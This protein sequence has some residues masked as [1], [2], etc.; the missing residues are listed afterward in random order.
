M[1][2]A[3]LSSPR[4]PA[5]SPSDPS[6]RRN[7][8]Q[9]RTRTSALVAALLALGATVP[10]AASASTAPDPAKA[11]W[12]VSDFPVQYAGLSSIEVEGDATVTVGFAI[13]AGFRFVAL[14]AAWDGAQWTR[15]RVRLHG[16]AGDVQLVDVDI[17]SASRGWAVGRGFDDA[18]SRAITARWNGTKWR[19]VSADGLSGDI[20]FAGVAAVGRKDV[21]AVGQEQVGATIIASIA[22][23]DGDAW[24]AVKV[25]PLHD[26]G[27]Y[28]ALSSIAEGPDGDLWAV[29]LGG[30][31]LRYD[32]SAWEQ[33]PVPKISGQYVD[34]QKVRSFD[35][36]GI[37]AV[38][39]AIVNHARLPV[40]LHWTGTKWQ[41]VQ[42][43]A[44]DH[45]QLNDVS[46]T[47]TGVVAIGYRDDGLAFYG[48]T[49]DPSG[50]AQP[51]KLPEGHDALFGSAANDAGTD[52]WVV[53]SGS[54]G[55]EGKIAPYAAVRR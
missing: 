52:L 13:A 49:L 50:P 22:H 5:L 17:T 39:Y 15:Q 26:V 33:V 29:G 27:F 28:T 14:A 45:A 4:P 48:L 8:R 3:L 36:G 31:S 51:L 43:P 9:R 42:V 2:A 7:R 54:V 37:W 41:T 40:A 10:A 1:P 53:G 38:G 44:G 11:R 35:D 6:A 32:G 23:Y 47:A 12:T 55:T 46:E 34:L 19:G 30:V 20:G 25:P 16:A 24:A 18:G 21:W